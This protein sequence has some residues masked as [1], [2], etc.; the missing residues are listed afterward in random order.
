MSKLIDIS[1]LLTPQIAVWPGDSPFQ[2]EPVMK[3][4][5]GDSV[6]L[7][8]L[9]MSAHTGTHI[10][11]PRHFKDNGA[12][13]EALDLSKYWGPA[14][15]VT[16]TKEIGPLFP[17][18]FDHVDL[19]LAPRLLVRSCSSGRDTTIFDDQIV[20]PSSVLADFLG[21]AGIVLYGADGPSMDK[22]DDVELRGHKALQRNRIAILEGLQLAHVKDGVYDFVA[23]PLNIKNGDGSPVRAV[24]RQLT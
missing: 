23:L 10:D 20:Y 9:T 5:N 7:T 14:Q 16:V 17:N 21:A 15:V 4:C 18:D 1:R 13:I 11:A 12:S 24:L 19:T 8:T 22:T 6:N 2:I 3:I